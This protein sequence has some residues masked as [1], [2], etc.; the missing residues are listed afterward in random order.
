[1]QAGRI[2]KK[3][4]DYAFIAVCQ[5]IA[6]N[7][8]VIEII[9]MTIE[10]H[11]CFRMSTVLQH[12]RLWNWIP[13]LVEKPLSI[14]KLRDWSHHFSKATSAILRESA[15]SSVSNNYSSLMRHAHFTWFYKGFWMEVLILGLD[16]LR[17]QNS[18]HVCCELLSEMII[19]VFKRWVH[20]YSLYLNPLFVHQAEDCSQLSTLG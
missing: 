5:E 10:Y 9:S 16:K 4:I 18:V 20:C 11:L 14:E 12:I 6:S 1:M 13:T 19:W 15:D 17:R 7:I 2:L 8:P 3:M